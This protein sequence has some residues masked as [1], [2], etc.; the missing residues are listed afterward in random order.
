MDA[1]TAIKDA[2][3]MA[4][5]VSLAYLGDLDDTELMQRPH[6]ACN[7][8][9]WQIGHLI[10]SEH[11]MM[12]K[13]PGNTMPPLPNG[14]S[15]MY[16][17]EKAASDS[18]ADFASKD[19]LMTAYKTQRAA[20]LAALDVTSAEQFDQPTGID[21]AP[22]VGSLFAMQGAHWMMHCGQWVIVRRNCGKPV[23]I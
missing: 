22:T 19:E 18:A 17:K 3:A 1:R 11:E 14:F 13:L 4:E 15:E 20:T 2:L 5:M 7:H 23:V 16:S 12:S 8:L 21:Y 9:N 10:S 6:A